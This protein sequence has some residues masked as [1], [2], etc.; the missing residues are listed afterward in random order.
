MLEV[1]CF[2]AGYLVGYYGAPVVLA[3]I[4]SYLP[5]KETPKE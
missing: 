2:G 1:L 5:K 3:Y 4:K